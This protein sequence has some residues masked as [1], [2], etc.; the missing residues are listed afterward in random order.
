[1]TSDMSR[2]QFSIP[3]ILLLT[4]LL[5]GCKTLDIGSLT[6]SDAEK[7]LRT[8]LRGYEATLRWGFPG[9][10]YNFLKPELKAKSKIPDNL[11]NIKVTNYHVLQA[12]IMQGEKEETITA[13]QGVVILYVFEDR[14]IERKLVDNQTWEYIPDEKTWVRTNP[15][16]EFK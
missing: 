2:A 11:D 8:A 12:P 7:T 9:Q 5:A 3:L 16:P 14:Q 6:K 1:M 10:A 13:E 4:L 15:I